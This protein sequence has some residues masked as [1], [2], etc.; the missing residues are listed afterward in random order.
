MNRICFSM[1]L[2]N[3]KNNKRHYRAYLSINAMIV[4]FIYLFNYIANNDGIPKISGGSTIKLLLFMGIFAVGI[5]SAIFQFYINS[6]LMKRRK[7]EYGLYSILGLEKKHIS[8]IMLFENII[9]FILSSIIGTTAGI[10]SSKAIFKLL[11]KLMKCE[12]PFDNII[13]P[14]NISITLLMF[15]VVSVMVYIYNVRIIYK[16]NTINMLKGSQKATETTKKESIFRLIAGIAMVVY[17]C[18]KLNYHVKVF[19]SIEVMFFNVIVLLLGTYLVY[20]AVCYFVLK[21]LTKV[22]NIYYKKNNFFPISNMLYRNKQTAA[23]LASICIILTVISI[24]TSTT[25]SLYAGTEAQ[26]KD[27]LAY[28]G[29]TISEK[30]DGDDEI[31]EEAA[32]AAAASSG[33]KLKNSVIYHPLIYSIFCDD[34]SNLSFSSSNGMDMCLLNILTQDD[35][36]IVQGDSISIAENEAAV[37][38]ENN[39]YNGK[40]SITLGNTELKIA[41][42]LDSFKLIDQQSKTSSLDDI[43]VIVA[44][45]A[46][47]N[48]LME[49]INAAAQRTNKV[50]TYY[51]FGSEG[52]EENRILFE[53][54]LHSNLDSSPI[55]LDK[56]TTKHIIRDDAYAQNSVYLFLGFFLSILFLSLMLVIMYHK[57]LQEAVDDTPKYSIMRKIGCSAAQCRK[58]IRNQSCIAY[59]A[60]VLLAGVYSAVMY[61]VICS[62]LRVFLLGDTSVIINCIMFTFTAV[63]FVYLIGYLVTNRV[64]AKTVLEQK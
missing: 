27:A 32:Q 18:I 6:F 45:E 44:N 34:N 21:S 64:Y 14:L 24:I 13:K 28:D 39:V 8:K 51:E 42:Y 63:F 52:S 58:I 46:V 29:L 48:S 23:G 55:S 1:A 16:T 25:V 36:N 61:R 17:A 57:Q 3:L 20:E 19:G 59:F 10:I 7:K 26:V 50:E 41:S 5:F 47:Q 54:T 38:S 37:V 49:D 4:M 11:L 31:I 35:Y 33:V 53:K 30:I 22:S 56:F 12:V 15:F 40:D 62:V 2:S 9:L 43:Y 60:P